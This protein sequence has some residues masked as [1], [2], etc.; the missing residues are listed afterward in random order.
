MVRLLEHTK[1]LENVVLAAF[2]TDRPCQTKA[3]LPP[4]AAPFSPAPPTP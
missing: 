2:T 4:S 3:N 1:A